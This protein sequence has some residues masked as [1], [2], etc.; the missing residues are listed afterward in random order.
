MTGPNINCP[1]KIFF[2]VAATSVL[3]KILDRKLNHLCCA[4]PKISSPYS[5]IRNVLIKSYEAKKLG[6]VII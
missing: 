4:G 3:G 2:T 1:I 6:S 5:A